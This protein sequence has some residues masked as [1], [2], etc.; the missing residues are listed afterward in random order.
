MPNPP[1]STRNNLT[2][3]R[4]GDSI[5]AKHYNTLVDLGRDINRERKTTP[6]EPSKGWLPLVCNNSGS[7]APAFS[8]LVLDHPYYTNGNGYP[9]AGQYGRNYIVGKEPT[10]DDSDV[11]AVNLYATP[12]GAVN[13]F[14]VSGA[15]FCLVRLTEQTLNCQYA[16]TEAGQI[17]HLVAADSGQCK[18]VWVEKREAGNQWAYVLLNVGGGGEDKKFIGLCE[19]VYYDNSGA[20]VT[21]CGYD[22]NRLTYD[23]NEQIG[24]VFP[25]YIETVQRGG[26][27]LVEWFS[28]YNRWIVVAGTCAEDKREYQPYRTVD[29]SYHIT[30]GNPSA[31]DPK[32][33]TAAS[34]YSHDEFSTF[35]QKVIWRQDLINYPGRSANLFFSEPTFA[36]NTQRNEITFDNLKL[37]PGAAGIYVYQFVVTNCNGSCR[38][39]YTVA[40]RCFESNSAP[41]IT[42]DTKNIEI[43]LDGEFDEDI[44]T[45]E[46]LDGDTC[47]IYDLQTE[48]ETSILTSYD[49]TVDDTNNIHLSLKASDSEV[50]SCQI[51]FYV[52]DSHELKATDGKY[53]KIT[54]KIT[55][56]NE[57][58]NVKLSQGSITQKAGTTKTYTIGTVTDPEDD[59]MSIADFRISG[60]SISSASVT[61]DGDKLKATITLKEDAT[62][63][64]YI[65]FKVED[66]F[67]VY[68]SGEPSVQSIDVTPIPDEEE[69]E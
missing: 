46:E 27:Y 33:G 40:F 31:S 3:V 21:K 30:D 23:T 64:G 17:G 15:V 54:L 66:E 47:V 36:F 45:I 11:V 61:I 10:G 39:V 67:G 43:H 58:P 5:S 48:G 6:N 24:V 2:H 29:V 62:T 55:V 59:N 44:G 4:K 53:E 41:K 19:E 69:S 9:M 49:L 38:D 20:R 32:S 12:I 52:D 65:Y 8:I 18:I 63:K 1:E 37:N 51:S 25:P 14:A 56:T 42:M 57:A 22:G 26:Y 68:S 34:F 28:E 35:T 13:R 50:G 16:K 60:D 7:F